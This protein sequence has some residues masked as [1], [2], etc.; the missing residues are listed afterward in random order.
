M[1]I[2]SLR[3]K[4]VRY[5]L[6]TIRAI[7]DHLYATYANISSADLQD[8]DAV[9]CTPYDIN[10]PIESLFDRVEKG[11]NRLVYIIRGAEDRVVFL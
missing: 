5:S 6:T 3:Y 1:F 9:F 2:R 11:F 8:N 10:Q 7:M 4:Y